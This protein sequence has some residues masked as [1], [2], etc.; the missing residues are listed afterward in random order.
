MSLLG[1]EEDVTIDYLKIDVEGAEIPFLED[2]LQNT[3]HILQ[4]R[5]D[6]PKYCS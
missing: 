3:P 6:L 2:V 1:H 5:L 4:V